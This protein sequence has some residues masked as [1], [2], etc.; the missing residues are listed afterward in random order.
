MASNVY[1][2]GDLGIQRGVTV[3]VAADHLPDLTFWVSRARVAVIVQHSK[4]VSSSGVG[5]V[6]KWSKTQIESHPPSSATRATLV[7]VSYCS[8]GFSISAR[9]IRHPC[10]TKTPNL[11][12]TVCLLSLSLPLW[13]GVELLPPSHEGAW[14]SWPA[15]PLRDLYAQ[16][17]RLCR[18]RSLPLLVWQSLSAGGL[19]IESIA[20]ALE[21]VMVLVEKPHQNVD[22]SVS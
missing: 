2:R 16:T 12:G 9:S 8:M 4:Q 14:W 10:G 5:T 15:P 21:R 6:W 22:C 20:P 11:I 7:M 17:R 3:A 13:D 19:Q 1:C 18:H